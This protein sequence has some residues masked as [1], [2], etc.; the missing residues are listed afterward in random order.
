[1]EDLENMLKKRVDPLT[2]S[3]VEQYI[4][5]RVESEVIGIEG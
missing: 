2:L 3:G 1:V 5:S 4:R